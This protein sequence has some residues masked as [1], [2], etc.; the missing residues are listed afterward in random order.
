MD[1]NRISR[2]DVVAWLRLALAPRL[3]PRDQHA[4]LAI[5]GTPQQVLAAP[6]ERIAAIVGARA[7][8]ALRAGASGASVDAALR[9]LE[10]SQHHVVPRSDA[11]YP[12]ALL[13]I[14]DPPSLLYAVGRVELLDRP[15]FAIVG[16]R[17][18][19][20]Q[21]ARDAEELARALSDAGLAIVS[22]LALGIDAAAHRGGLAARGSSIAW[23]GT[24]A[25]TVYP[26]TNG[27]L[28]AR[29]A[30]E[31]C[32]VSEFP[33]G[34]GPRPGNFPQRNRLIS[35]MSRGVLV[36]EAALG[37]G[38]LIT[39]RRALD[40]GRDVFAVPGSIHSPLSKGCHW[41]IQ[42]GAKLVQ[43]AADVLDELGWQ[44][45]VAPAAV[46]R[47]R[48]VESDPVLKAMGP[49]PIS[50]DEVAQLTG[51]DAAT[52][53]SRVS[54]LELDGRVAVLAGGLFQRLERTL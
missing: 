51:L 18:A 4:L 42:Q 43:S 3:L 41:L 26:S 23:T 22:G 48:R 9:W 50:L 45:P 13:E 1:W 21:G 36:V 27:A 14:S 17:N 29:L 47:R 37:S 6:R 15:A 30:S 40:Q 5:L 2:E 34:T 11:R 16:S 38:S 33:L 54:R 12:P 32:V 10:V 20:V 53:A 19:T 25:D 24:G 31:G 49:A 44:A 46:R 39:A 7:A 8:E 52:I 28:A 35:G